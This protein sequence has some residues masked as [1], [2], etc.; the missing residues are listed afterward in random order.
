MKT[1]NLIIPCQRE[2]HGGPTGDFNQ[3]VLLKGKIFACTHSDCY[4]NL[5]QKKDLICFYSR[6][7]SCLYIMSGFLVVSIPSLLGTN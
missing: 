7:F 3:N 6:Y 5:K 4:L 2:K 1:K